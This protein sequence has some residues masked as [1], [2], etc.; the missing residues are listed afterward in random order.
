R[1]VDLLA[2]AVEL[3]PSHGLARVAYASL[4]LGSETPGASKQ[5]LRQ[6]E[7]AGSL[8][9]PPLD[10]LV[11]LARLHAVQGRR[12]AAGAVFRQA[13]RLHPGSAVLMLRYGQ[14]LLEGSQE[15]RRQAVEMLER[16][17]QLP[18]LTG[19]GHFS[20]GSYWLSCGQGT[21]CLHHMQRADEQGFSRATYFLGKHAQGKG[22]FKEAEERYVKALE[23]V[24]T[25]RAALLGYLDVVEQVKMDLRL[26]RQAY[27]RAKR[28]RRKN[29]KQPKREQA[30]EGKPKEALTRGLRLHT[31]LQEYSDL[32][33][34]ELERSG[35]LLGLEER[36][37]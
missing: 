6:L 19:E 28:R 11:L 18:G 3:E 8:P 25:N 29:R 27:A 9:Q 31:R 30:Q 23:A 36:D 26:A 5:A 14:F 34:G 37:G 22:D 33:V 20:C 17:S 21:R 13:A 12:A 15:E 16:A 24:P 10:G 7:S 2:Q 4:L 32:L 1:A 35:R